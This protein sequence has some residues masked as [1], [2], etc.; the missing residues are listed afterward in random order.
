MP[1]TEYIQQVHK[2]DNGELV[3]VVLRNNRNAKLSIACKI[4]KT[5]WDVE[6]PIFGNIA[7]VTCVPSIRDVTL[8]G[9]RFG[10]VPARITC[11]IIVASQL[12]QHVRVMAAIPDEWVDPQ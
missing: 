11:P 6:V 1:A 12:E 3:V 4:C 2:T 9:V 7:T 5:V 8:Y 10:L